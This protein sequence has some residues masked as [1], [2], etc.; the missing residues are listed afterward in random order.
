M[1]A[2]RRR[3]GVIMDPAFAGKRSSDVRQTRKRIERDPSQRTSTGGGGSPTSGAF[4]SLHP[5]QDSRRT[6]PPKREA[7]FS[8]FVFGSN[9]CPKDVSPQGAASLL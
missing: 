8:V 5:L 1:S 6:P 2:G 3:L 4:R 7:S 9:S